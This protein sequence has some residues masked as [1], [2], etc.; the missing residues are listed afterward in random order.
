MDHR[1]ELELD[2]LHPKIV[3]FLLPIILLLS[4]SFQN[5]YSLSD[6][7]FGAAGDL[8]CT[9]NAENI[10]NGIKSK[11]P[12]RVLGLGDYSYQPTATCWLNDNATHG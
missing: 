7:N 11:N 2:K 12:E 4:I 9:S 10:N 1:A 8:G 6:F 3:L 5:S